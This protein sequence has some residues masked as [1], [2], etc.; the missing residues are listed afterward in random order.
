MVGFPT[1]FILSCP[2]FRNERIKRRKNSR[3][4]AMKHL[5]DGIK[6]KFKHEVCLLHLLLFQ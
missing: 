5:I 3:E 4:G 2:L 1:F 6:A